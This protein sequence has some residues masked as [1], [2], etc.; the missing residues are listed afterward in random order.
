MRLSYDGAPCPMRDKTVM[1]GCEGY[2]KTPQMEK[3]ETTGVR[4]T[5]VFGTGL[6]LI[7]ATFLGY[8]LFMR[9]GH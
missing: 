2:T 9:R 4:A 3:E 7:G 1:Q 5:T 6:I 8:M